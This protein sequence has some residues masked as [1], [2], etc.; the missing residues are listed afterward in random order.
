MYIDAAPKLVADLNDMTFEAI[1]APRS[2][3]KWP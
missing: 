2:A 3:M 1:K